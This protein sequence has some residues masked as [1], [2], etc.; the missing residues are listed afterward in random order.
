M[1]NVTQ[2]ANSV[3]IYSLCKGSS[4]RHEGASGSWHLSMGLYYHVSETRRVDEHRHPSSLR[5]LNI[6]KFTSI[7]N[8]KR[9]YA[10]GRTT[11]DE[12][13]IPENVKLY[14]GDV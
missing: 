12:N 5:S 14:F 1:E 13:L 2:H 4:P 7:Y 6:W 9:A 3:P 8:C 10:F 11:E